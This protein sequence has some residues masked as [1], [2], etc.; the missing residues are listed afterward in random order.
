MFWV[1]YLMANANA[2]GDS[3]TSSVLVSN[4]LH[5]GRLQRA[6]FA[7]GA[8]LRAYLNTGPRIPSSS[9]SS[10]SS[11]SVDLAN[12]LVK[13]AMDELAATGRALHSL[14]LFSLNSA[15]LQLNSEHLCVMK[16]DTFIGFWDNLRQ[17]ATNGLK[18]S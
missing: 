7:S 2:D 11:S 14:P 18:L 10:F 16:W 12:L 9:S 15:Y 4:H 8:D 17:P 3:V 5:R 1:P 6:G 13:S